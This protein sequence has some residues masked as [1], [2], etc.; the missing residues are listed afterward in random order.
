M[1]LLGE[2]AAGSPVR[3]I[4]DGI[5]TKFII[6]EWIA[7]INISIAILRALSEK[8]IPGIPY[9]T[10]IAILQ[11]TD[12]EIEENSNAKI[13]DLADSLR[14]KGSLSVK[15]GRSKTTLEQVIASNTVR[16]EVQRKLQ[17]KQHNDFEK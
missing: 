1:V 7:N 8:L 9:A 4:C 5:T 13:E 16:T 6:D 15:K 2:T 3:G 11:Q 14:E 17:G 10:R 12:A